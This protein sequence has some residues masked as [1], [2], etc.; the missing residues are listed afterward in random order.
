MPRAYTIATAAL[1]L[2][3]PIKWLDNTLSHYRVQ[4]VTQ[5][6]QG[7]SRRL[8]IESLTIL[9]IALALVNDLET[10]LPKALTLATALL[11]SGGQLDLPTGAKIQL[12][13]EQTSSALLERLEHAVEIAPLPR[14]GRPP[15][16]ATGR[17]D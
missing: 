16:K 12:D 14:R 6:R 5:E 3:V 13:I 10:P 11:T 1:A 7:I 15:Q 9:A 2:Q 4:G 17:L 8:S